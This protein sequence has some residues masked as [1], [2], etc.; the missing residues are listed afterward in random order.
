M[1][2]RDRLVDFLDKYFA[3]YLELAKARDLFF[4]GLQVTGA[5]AVEKVGLGVSCGLEFFERAHLAGCNFLVTHH[6]LGFGGVEKAGRLLPHHELR[7]RFLYQKNISLVGYHFC[8]DRHPEIG[9]NAW[10]IKKLGGEIIGNIFDQW[11]WFGHFA[12]PRKLSEIIKECETIYERAGHVVGELK[13][14]IETFAVVSGSGA[15]DYHNH[16]SVQEFIEKGIE[17]EIVGDLREGHP[18]FAKE[19]GLTLAAFGHYNTETIGVKNLGEVIKREFP[20][21]PVEFVE[22]SNEL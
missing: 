9:N 4:N 8:L 12:Q 15:V 13:E 10:V 16:D 6:G 5:E 20:D 18:A 11:G 21:L 22:V 3:P 1:I 2:K 17:L 7:L 14:E 19:I